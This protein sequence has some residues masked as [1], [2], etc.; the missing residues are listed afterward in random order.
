[1]PQKP[2]AFWKSRSLAAM[3]LLPLAALFWLLVS[4]R[5]SLFRHGVLA[6]VRLPVPVIVV[7]NI[8]V[9]GSGK[10]PVVQ[11]LIDALRGAGYRPG[12]VSRGYGGAFEGVTMVDADADPARYGDE[13][14]L[15]ARTCGCPV[16]VGADRPAAAAR[17]LADHPECD[18]LV[19]DDGL[20]HYRLQRDIEVVVVDPDTLANRWLLP[21]GPLRE[22]LSRL[23]D[24][25]V[26]VAHGVL[27][28]ALVSR[29]GTTP[30]KRM[31]LAGEQLQRLGAPDDSVPLSSFAGRRVHAI[32]GIGRPER[33]FAQLAAAGL[34]VVPHA[35]PDHHRF[36]AA[37]LA[38]DE[39]APRIMTAKDAVKCV[40]FALADAWV[41]PVAARIEP[42]MQDTILEK[43]KHGRE[44][45]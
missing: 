43:L 31:R 16:A 40:I 23:A 3:C 10:T 42:G 28:P 25:D 18:V 41:L 13:P 26:V 27:D 30:V 32:A 14:V 33:F 21:S 20:Q 8:A 2:P 5:R 44:A 45:A 11:W 38:F 34:D 1:M 17:L 29:C 6:S 9:G 37:D 19:S 4:V 15:L 24:C 22:G 36:E 39:D 12:I 35:F 7:G